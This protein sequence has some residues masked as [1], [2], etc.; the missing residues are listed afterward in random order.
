MGIQEP[1]PI[2]DYPITQSAE[3]RLFESKRL[4]YFFACCGLIAGAFFLVG[5]IAADFLPPMPPSYTAEQVTAHYKYHQT[6]IH[7]FAAFLMIA[8][9]FWV[10]YVVVISDQMRRIPNIPWAFPAL[11]LASG[12]VSTAGFLIPGLVLGV[13]GLRVERDPRELQL[14]NDMFWLTVIMTFQPFIVMSWVW[15]Y[16]IFKDNRDTP[17][18]PKYVAYVACFLSTMFL[19]SSATHVATKGPFAWDGALGFWVP[20]AALG[21]QLP[22]ETYF[23]LRAIRRDYYEETRKV[24]SN[25]TC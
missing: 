4:H 22:G 6:G 20:L 2:L 3:V 15:S 10:P 9:T 21:I 16:A 24:K 18:Y 1:H 19:W 17:L 5:F 14:L 13:A 12:V 7:V 8:C 25:G 23:L 11:Q